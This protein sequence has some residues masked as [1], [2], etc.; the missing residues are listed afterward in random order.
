MDSFHFDSYTSSP[1]SGSSAPRTPSPR[2]SIS[3]EAPSPAHFKVE[4][5]PICNIF[6]DQM[7]DDH[8]VPP[9]G[10][11]LWQGLSHQSL[12]FNGSRSS[13]VKSLILL[14][15]NWLPCVGLPIPTFA[16]IVMPQRPILKHLLCLRT[17]NQSMASSLA[18]IPSMGNISP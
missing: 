5:E 17:A 9:E 15:R 10:H 13:L 4:L 3:D 12:P 18:P 8:A 14:H 16:R 1:Y 6:S 7:V 11:S 2:T